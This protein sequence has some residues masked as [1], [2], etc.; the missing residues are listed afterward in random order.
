M[1]TVL[2]IAQRE[3]AAYLR[4]MSGYVIMAVMLGVDGLAPT[5]S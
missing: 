1:N 3:L 4:T 2:L 5:P